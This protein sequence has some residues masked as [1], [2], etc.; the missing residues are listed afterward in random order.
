MR[1]FL[2]KVTPGI[3][4]KEYYGYCERIRSDL[5]T[6]SDNTV[7]A[8]AQAL[9][10]KVLSTADFVAEHPDKIDEWVRPKIVNLIVYLEKHDK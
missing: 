10:Q 6:I 7:K 9:F 2:S 3:T 5:S 1:K 4:T 8:E